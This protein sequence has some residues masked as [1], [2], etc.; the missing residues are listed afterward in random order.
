MAQSFEI[1]WPDYNHPQNCSIHVRNEL[2][3]DATPERLWAWLIHAT[4][5]PTWYKHAANVIS[6]NG[7]GSSL[8]MGSTFSWRTMGITVK[9]TVVEYVA[10]ERI[11]WTGRA[12]G[13][14]VYHAWVLTP[15]TSGCNVLTEETQRGFLAGLGR[16]F[17]PAK[18][19]KAH[20]LWL[21]C[22]QDKARSGL[23]QQN[24]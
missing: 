19:H 23:P 1:Q 22:L 20:Q 16:M 3:I 10:N 11:A 9:C 18:M 24:H 15:L 17:L 7:A 12:Y 13:I 6:L 8:E 5:W 4:L 2:D 21:E 14:D